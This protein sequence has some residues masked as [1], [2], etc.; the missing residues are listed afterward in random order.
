GRARRGRNGSSASRRGAFQAPARREVPGAGSGSSSSSTTRTGTTN[1]PEERME[2]VRSRTSPA[3]ARRLPVRD[4]D[5]T[6]HLPEAQQG[7]RAGQRT[8]QAMPRWALRA[9]GRRIQRRQEGG[10]TREERDLMLEPEVIDKPTGALVPY[11]PSAPITLF[12]TSDPDQALERMGKIAQ[13]LVDVIEQKGLFATIG[14]HR[15]IT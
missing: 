14:G 5:P 12:G 9:A 11:E 10:M 7:R 8:L 6:C 4:A 3:A 15:H 2:S 1:E 13:T